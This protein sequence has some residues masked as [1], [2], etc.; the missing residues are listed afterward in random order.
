MRAAAQALVLL[1]NLTKVPGELVIIPA[2]RKRHL[3]AHPLLG[4][5]RFAMPG[6][7]FALEDALSPEAECCGG[8]VDGLLVSLSHLQIE[9][10]VGSDDGN[11]LIGKLNIGGVGKT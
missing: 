9:L 11:A 4:A 10:E 8:K 7:P 6:G 1:P 2:A 5:R 3:V